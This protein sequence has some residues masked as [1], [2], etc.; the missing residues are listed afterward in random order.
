[1]GPRLALQSLTP[2]SLVRA[3]SGVKLE[4]ARKIVSAVH[5]D[6]GLDAPMQG[7]RRASLDAVR[8]AGHV[9]QLT[10]KATRSSSVDPF[11]K[12]ALETHDAHVIETVRIPLERAGRYSVCVS[13]QVGCALACAFCA[14]GRMGLT[15]NLETWE[16]VE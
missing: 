12:L 8:A 6:I 11:V 7:V 5:R 10:L 4:E 14:T 13:S 9:P 2:A 3:V 16:I 1:M 15:R